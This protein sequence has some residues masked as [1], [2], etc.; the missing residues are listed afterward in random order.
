[1]Q[2]SPSNLRHLGLGCILDLIIMSVLLTISRR[3]SRN[4]L[5]R[6]SIERWRKGR[7]PSH[8]LITLI[9]RYSRDCHLLTARRA[10]G[11]H[12]FLVTFKLLIDL[13]SWDEERWDWTCWPW[14][15]QPKY[16]CQSQQIAVSNCDLKKGLCEASAE[17]SPWKFHQ[18]YFPDDGGRGRNQYRRDYVGPKERPHPWCEVSK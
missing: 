5:S 1:M 10:R 12:Q 18:H 6:W 17:K 8:L 13:Y 15:L 7:R 3:C 16:G 14:K 9:L 4:S 2:Q 11:F